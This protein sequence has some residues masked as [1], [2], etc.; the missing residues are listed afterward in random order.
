MPVL[1]APPSNDNFENAEIIST[2]P[3]TSTVDI[4]EAGI[5]PNEPQ[6]CLPTDRSVWYSFTPSQ[7]MSVRITRGGSTVFSNLSVYSSTGPTLSDLSFYGCPIFNPAP[8]VLEAGHTYYI[9]AEAYPG[10]AGTIQV[11][12]EQLFPPANDD[13][14]NAEVI[15]S[16]PFT[17]MVDISDAWNETGEPGSCSPMEKTVW[18]L[19]TPSENM[20]VSLDTIGGTSFGRAAAYVSTGSGFS[21]INLLGCVQ[22]SLNFLAEGGKTYYLQIGDSYNSFAT[23]QINLRQIFPPANDNFD[24]ATTIP[25]LPYATNIN[26]ITDATTETD[27]PQFCSF[28]DKT[29]WFLFAPTETMMVNA[30]AQ[31]SSAAGNMNIYRATGS[32]FSNLQIITCTIFDSPLFLAEAGQTYYIQAGS[33]SGTFGNVQIN[34][35]QVPPPVNDNFASATPIISL[36]SVV[37]FDISAATFQNNEKSPSCAYPAP[38]YQTVWFTYTATQDGSISASIP[39]FNFSPFIAAYSGP[40]LNNL[41]ESG[42]NQYSNKITI[43]VVS[44]QTY[45]FQVGGLYTNRGIGQFLLETTPPPQPNFYNYPS[46]P[47][48]FDTIQYFDNSYDPG[49]V[50]LQSFNWDFGDGSVASGNSVTHKYASDGDYQITHSVTTID[51]RTASIVQTVQIRTHDVSIVKISAPNSANAGQTKT[52]SVNLR[53]LTYP[54]TVQID[55]YKSTPNGFVWVATITKS[56]P[57][58]SGNR[59]TTV[60]FSYKFTS[61]DAKLGKVTFKAVVSIVGARDAYPSDNEGISSIIKVAK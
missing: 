14:S 24:N 3:F 36:P 42:C 51:G 7:T 20:M 47:S 55:L 52:I 16:L 29:V 15:T 6:S 11:N 27:E 34:L 17:T 1:A 56:V 2:L 8:L 39:N 26:N 50:G 43:H 58:L 49:N 57:V 45:Y 33:V 48:R 28:M 31:G 19:F 5:E 59:T 35:E 38:P 40:D 46:D 21:S 10:E 30:T 37:D 54:E 60:D 18:Y 61:E 23:I 53:N 32:G 25:S 12:M 4:T 44:G 22:G 41:I 13:F 9:Q